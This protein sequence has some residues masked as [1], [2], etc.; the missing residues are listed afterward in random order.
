MKFHYITFVINNPKMKKIIFLFLALTLTSFSQTQVKI[1]AITPTSVCYG[2]SVQVSYKPMSS[3][4]QILFVQFDFGGVNWSDPI[5]V[6][7]GYASY[8]TEYKTWLKIPVQSPI[9]VIGVCSDV[10]LALSVTD[11]VTTGIKQ[12]SLDESIPAYYDLYGNSIDKRF[13]ELIVEQRDGLRRK[14]IFQN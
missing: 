4:S 6:H 1:T 10:C 8:V 13:N 5:T 2:D 11:C 14:V 7:T 3:G 9:G 12:Y